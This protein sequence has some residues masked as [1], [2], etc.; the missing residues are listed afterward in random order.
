MLKAKKAFFITVF[1][2]FCLAFNVQRIENA[3]ISAKSLKRHWG[4]MDENRAIASPHY[5]KIQQVTRMGM[6]HDPK[7][8]EYLK[9]YWKE[10]DV[11]KC[12]MSVYHFTGKKIRTMIEKSSKTYRAEYYLPSGEIPVFQ[13][14]QSSVKDDKFVNKRLEYC[15]G[16][17]RSQ[18]YDEVYGSAILIY[19][20]FK[21][22]V[23]A[24]LIDTPWFYMIP[25]GDIRLYHKNL[26]HWSIEE[27][28]NSNLRRM[29]RI[30]EEEY[31]LFKNIMENWTV[32][33][34]IHLLKDQDV[35]ARK[36]AAEALIIKKDSRAVESLIDAL[37]DNSR[38][39]RIYAAKAL[40]EIGDQRAVEPL[41]VTLKEKDN[42]VQ[43]NAAE[44]LGKIK[45]PRAA[46]PLFNALK[47]YFIRSPARSA[48]HAIEASIPLEILI[49]KAK[50]ENEEV[51]EFSVRALIKRKDSRA[52]ESL[53]NALSY[54]NPSLLREV[55]RALK[56]MEASIPLGFLIGGLNSANER[57]FRF[58]FNTLESI[59][60]PA[61]GLLITALEDVNEDVKIS[62][63]RLL[64]KT[65][66]TRATEP[67]I[68]VL[69]DRNSKVRNYAADALGSI[70]DSRAVEPL[71]A[72][73][74]DENVRK[75]AAKAL[76]NITGED[77]RE[78]YKK[79][80]KWWKKNKKR[81]IKKN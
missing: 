53:F 12:S 3:P 41:I 62:A 60:E 49:T 30:T 23:G 78:D 2:V 61:V 19:R 22:N 68:N 52:I 66:D 13:L 54:K 33:Y 25:P 6:S 5:L 11:N 31:E 77:F 17:G 55:E 46:E 72:V 21:F 43:A 45:D 79:W 34:I 15:A 29:E 64:K 8:A 48:L 32:D 57:I 58:S 1:F 36:C 63:C 69:N 16:E 81:Y 44:A 70:G 18:I 50:D 65:K 80:Q 14:M 26:F 27:D 42:P 51:R 4:E 74:Y 59:G 76:K 10:L 9:G 67:L 75:T 7:L 28:K 35:N 24:P 38:I 20:T 39:I 73:L 56:E 40:G 47:D 37:K 71:I